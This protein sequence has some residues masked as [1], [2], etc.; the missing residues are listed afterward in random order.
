MGSGYRTPVVQAEGQA[1]VNTTLWCGT[2]YRHSQTVDRVSI[3][4]TASVKLTGHL[5]GALLLRCCYL[6]W[7]RT[8]YCTLCTYTVSDSVST[9]TA[10]TV[11]VQYSTTSVQCQSAAA[12]KARASHSDRQQMVRNKY[13]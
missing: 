12:V 13:K 8:L 3:P 11:L 10:C 9:G 1:L 5:Y 2:D 4:P 7:Y 6:L